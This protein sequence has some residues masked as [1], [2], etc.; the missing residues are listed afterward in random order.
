MTKD[1]I[2]FTCETELTEKI[3]L[4]L[5]QTDYTEIIA[6]EKLL[7][8]DEDPIKVIK[9][10]MGINV[11]SKNV[12][13]KSLNQEIYRQLRVRLDDSIRDF[14]KK[15]DFKLKTEIEKNKNNKQ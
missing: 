2:S 12:A 6:R 15:Q 14:N 4:I 13:K 9:K 3:H 11:E 7:E 10:Y 8:N 1:N 5:R